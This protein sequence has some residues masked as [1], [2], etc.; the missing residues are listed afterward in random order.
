[1]VER[2]RSRVSLLVFV[3]MA[4]CGAGFW[5]GQQFGSEPDN[6][7]LEVARPVTATARTGVLGEEYAVPVVLESTQDLS[8]PFLADTGVVTTL[9]AEPG[10]FASINSGAVVGTVDGEPIVVIEGEHPA[11]RSMSLGDVGVDVVQLQDHLV[12]MGLLAGAD[13]DGSFGTTTEQAVEA[14]W[15]TLG[16]RG[17]DTV[18]TGSVM[19]VGGLPRLL[20]VDPSV[21]VGQLISTGAPLLVGVSSVPSTTVTLTDIQERRFLAEDAQFTVS[22]PTGEEVGLT[23]LGSRVRDRAAIV[24]LAFPAGLLDEW[25]DLSLSPGQPTR[26]SGT[27]IVTPQTEGTIVPLAALND[28][29]VSDATLHTESGNETVDVDVNVVAVV[30]GLAIVEPLEPGTVVLLGQ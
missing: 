30:G 16:V 20:S 21:R 7:A 18:P 23:V 29:A 22:G 11:Y 6:A 9:S 17:R 8:L 26:L 10:S 15:E 28:I 1:M 25:A 13:A 24:E 12:S 2:S 27:M 4:A 3:V 5:A 19:F 14:W